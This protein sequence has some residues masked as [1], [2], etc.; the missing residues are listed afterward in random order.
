[1]V[2][3]HEKYQHL[4]GISIK[5]IPT[6]SPWCR[7]NIHLNWYGMRLEYITKISLGLA[8]KS[9]L[10]PKSDMEYWKLQWNLLITQTFYAISHEIKNDKCNT[11]I[12]LWIHIG[13][14][15][16]TPT[17]NTWSVLFDYLRPFLMEEKG[18]Q[19][20][21]ASFTEEVNSR[22]AKR[23]LGFEWVFI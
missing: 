1:M 16:L 4:R 19:R 12:C 10:L 13:I 23:P 22:L 21:L 15:F 20:P 17:G 9:L 2:L 18:Y 14:L 3:R 8:W 11:Q 6:S 7:G 5:I